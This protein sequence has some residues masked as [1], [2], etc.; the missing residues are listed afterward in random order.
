M[1]KSFQSFNIDGLSY[2][3]GTG[4]QDYLIGQ[5]S[6]DDRIFKVIRHSDTRDFHCFRIF[7]E[8][9]ILDLIKKN[10]AVHEIVFKYPRRVYFDVDVK[11]GEAFNIFELLQNIKV[12]ISKDEVNVYGYKTEES[13]SYHITLS[14]T[15]FENDDERL[16][17]KEYIG[18]LKNI[19]PGVF[20]KSGKSDSIVDT[21]V[22]SITQAFKC[23]YQSKPGSTK[24]H[25]IIKGCPIRDIKN[26]FINSFISDERCPLFGNCGN[27]EVYKNFLS[28]G[29]VP[30]SKITNITENITPLSLPQISKEEYET[31]EGLLKLCPVYGDEGSDLGH[32]HRYKVLCFCYW[33][34]LNFEVFSDWFDVD[35]SNAEL[36]NKNVSNWHQDVRTRRLNKLKI[37]WNDIGKQEQYR[38][39]INSFRKYLMNF[40]PELDTPNDINTCRFLS[41]FKHSGHIMNL[42]GEYVSTS[43]FY[44]APNSI[45]LFNLCMGGGKTTATLKY[46]S[47]NPKKSFVWLAPRQ[48]LVLNTTERMRKEFNIKHINHL[49]VGTNKKKLTDADKLIICNQSLFHLKENNIYDVVIIDEIETVLNSWSDDETH[50]DRMETNFNRFC[51][52][53]RRAKKVILLDAF[54]TTKTY[55]FL[56]QLFNNQTNYTTYISDKKPPTKKLI[57]NNNYEELINKIA[58]EIKQGKKLYIYYAFKTSKN[59]R[60]GILDLDY[61]IKR[62]IQEL[63]EEEALTDSE[64]LKI[65]KVDT[66][67]YKNSL[68]YFA[69]SKEKN[70]LGN[71]NEKWA[72]ADFIITNTSITVGVNYEGVDYDKIYLLC[73]GST[74]S[75]RDIIQTSMRIRKTKEDIIELFFFDVINKDFLKYPKYYNSEDETY[76]KLI[77]DVYAEYHA[78]FVDS[79]R[80]FCD[81]T[82]YNYD[83]VPIIK[84]RES[85]RKQLFINDLF[86][87]N[88]LIEYSKIPNLDETNKELYENKI[89]ERKATLIERLAVDKYYFDNTYHYL[90][91]ESRCLLWNFKGR[92]FL[93]GMKDDIINLI[94]VDNNIENLSELDLKDIK[95]SDKTLEM[96]KTRFST[97][98]DNKL[99]NKIV[100][101]AINNLLGINAIQSKTED[102]GRSR[103]HMFTD[104]FN[105]MIKIYDEMTDYNKKMEAEENNKVQFIEDT[106]EEECFIE[107]RCIEENK[108]YQLFQKLKAQRKQIPE[109]LRKYDLDL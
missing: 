32:S 62:R 76:R 51:E 40:Y 72:T 69:E 53:I 11:N 22:Y 26:T 54:I 63:D 48:T 96:I 75:P 98:I 103:G 13:Q 9:E 85:V 73:S 5:C 97:T 65:M 104:L 35:P 12:Y 43:D 57:Q 89:F 60:D 61:R 95:I 36:N 82:G 88:M 84:N 71:V 34:G 79:F 49:E 16:K 68:V 27:S 56:N 101:K 59:T 41:S 80:K 58:S 15:Y 102:S 109:E 29:N 42:P 78:D 64:K 83:A 45:I 14:N 55:N 52:I 108:E 23:I 6:D 18:Y 21:K 38:V 3:S 2:K 20:G 94:K 1:G 24:V 50:K 90:Q 8:S 10:N 107:N 105:T 31:A 87:S 37:C 19:M 17:F 74:G 91:K 7:K 47:E 67:E 86:Q 70:D 28:V 92:S 25:N 39:S 93:S 30:Q 77:S 81:L 46:L 4:I 33:N 100:H 99:K 44:N 106:N 66:K